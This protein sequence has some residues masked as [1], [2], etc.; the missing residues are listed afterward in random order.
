MYGTR[1]YHDY[2]VSL[3]LNTMLGTNRAEERKR[4]LNRIEW[5]FNQT[6]LKDEVAILKDP[7]RKFQVFFSHLTH[8]IRY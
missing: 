7:G 4:W 1:K 2:C 8:Y 5:K 6:F 3:A